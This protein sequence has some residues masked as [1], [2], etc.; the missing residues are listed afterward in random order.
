MNFLKHINNLSFIGFFFSFAGLF[1]LTYHI[2]QQLVSCLSS[3]T[4]LWGIN[5]LTYLGLFLLVLC[6]TISLKKDLPFLWVPVF[7]LLLALY[8]GI[9]T[10]MGFGFYVMYSSCCIL[11]IYFIFIKLPDKLRRQLLHWFLILFNIVILLMFIWG[12][13]DQIFNKPIAKWLA[14]FMTYNGNYLNFAYATDTEGIR[15]YSFFGHPLVNS[16]LFNAFFAI[17]SLY[18]KHHKPLL[19]S[20]FCCII[21]LLSTTFCGSKTGF[22]IA[23]AIAL[24]VF[25][26]NIKS[27]IS[28]GIIFIGIMLSGLMNNLITRLLTQS[29][30]TGRITVLSAL[31]KDPNYSFHFLYGYGNF[32]APEYEPQAFEFPYVTFSFQYGILFALLILSTSFLYVTLKLCKKNSLHIWLIWLLLFGQVNTYTCL[33]QDL[34]NS[35][36]FYFLT[37]I[38]L[39][40][41]YDNLSPNTNT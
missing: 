32:M 26:R 4:F 22:F 7:A 9:R 24:I 25:Y 11:S 8:T 2:R 29:L 34:D 14:T 6:G 38:I 40:I 30:T 5:Y 21:C 17:N 27:L 28:L 16:T 13:I 19:P 20:F 18:N 12:L 37:M 31:I 39:N 10:S 36:I 15:F 1:I 35:L 23:L 33:A 41:Y 3:R